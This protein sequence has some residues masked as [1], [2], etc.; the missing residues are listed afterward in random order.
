MF[1]DSR[2]NRDRLITLFI[3][4]DAGLIVKL[5]VLLDESLFA[6]PGLWNRRYELSDASGLDDLLGRLTTRVHLPMPGRILVGRI[7][8][9][10]L[11]KAIFHRQQLP[12]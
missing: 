2:Y 1:T 12:S 6:L 5:E 11:K 9:R 4:G 10:M 8:N 3:G 7:E